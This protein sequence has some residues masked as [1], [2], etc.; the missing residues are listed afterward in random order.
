[1]IVEGCSRKE[2]LTR[3]VRIFDTEEVRRIGSEP[4]LV[5]LVEVASPASK[6]DAS[7]VEVE[8]L[9]VILEE[10]DKQKSDVA[11]WQ[12]LASLDLWM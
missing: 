2:K 1:M 9:A 8:V 11:L 3:I 6:S 7:L 12:N 10:F 5:V 4:P